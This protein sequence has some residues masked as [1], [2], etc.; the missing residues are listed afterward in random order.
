[1][2]GRVG[3]TFGEAGVNIISAAVGLDPEH[4]DS[5]AAVMVITTDGPAPQEVVDQIAASDGFVSGTS[6]SLPS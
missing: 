4:A 3:S 2:I 5:Q 1:M 6:V